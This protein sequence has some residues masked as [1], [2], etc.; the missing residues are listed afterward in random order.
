MDHANHNAS[1]ESDMDDELSEEAIKVMVAICELSGTVF[2]NLL[3]LH[4]GLRVPVVR[5]TITHLVGKGF[6]A[7]YDPDDPMAQ[8]DGHSFDDLLAGL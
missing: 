2:E 1:A 3:A 5:D 4:T 8:A 7:E 6:L